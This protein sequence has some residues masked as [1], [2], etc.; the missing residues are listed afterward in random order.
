M[1][2][3]W[4]ARPRGSAARTRAAPT[5]RDI[6]IYLFIIYN[7]VL[8]PSL[9]GKGHT[10]TNHVGSYKPD[11]FIIIFGV[12]LKPHLTYLAGDVQAR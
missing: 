10:H 5:W 12:G 11:G 8:C 7:K 1:D 9:Y 2:A 4:H 6:H 3:T